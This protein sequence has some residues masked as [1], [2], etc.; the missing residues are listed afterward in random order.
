M[1]APMVWQPDDRSGGAIRSGG[2]NGKSLFMCGSH[3][4]AGEY[5][6]GDVIGAQFV[7]TDTAAS[8]TQAAIAVAVV[9]TCCNTAASSGGRVAAAAAAPDATVVECG[10]GEGN[11]RGVLHGDAPARAGRWRGRAAVAASTMCDTD[12]CNRLDGL[13]VEGARGQQGSC[14]AHRSMHGSGMRQRGSRSCG[15]GQYQRHAPLSGGIMCC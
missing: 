9:V 3:R 11:W 14:R 8:V 13:A 4:R 10:R 1:A 15:H 5:C 12:S 6:C 7:R 2:S